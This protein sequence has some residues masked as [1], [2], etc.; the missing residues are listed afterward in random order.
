MK[1]VVTGGRD[2]ADRDHVFLV[3]DRLHTETPIAILIHGACGWDGDRPASF[4]R[5]L[6]GADGLADAWAIARA[7]PVERV[8]A[9]WA[10]GSKGGPLRNGLML[11]RSPALVVAFPGDRGTRNCVNQARQRGIRVEKA[12]PFSTPLF[13]QVDTRALPLDARGQTIPRRST[14]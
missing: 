7:V 10:N 6:R 8:P 9:R 4:A 13:A 2:Y 5:E 3:L 11:D 12:T 14:P 1:I